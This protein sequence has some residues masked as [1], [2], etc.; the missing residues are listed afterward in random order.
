V[1]Y[2]HA[3]ARA[4]L[5]SLTTY[6]DAVRA[7]IVGANQYAAAS[8]DVPDRLFARGRLMPTDRWLLLGIFDWRTGLPYSVVD[9]SL[10]FVG[11][12]NSLRLPTYDRLEVGIE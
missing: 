2:A 4:D 6:F 11:A 9:G 1:S 12:R 8:S 3:R 10:D 5:N 7:P